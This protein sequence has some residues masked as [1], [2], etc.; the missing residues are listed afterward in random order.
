MAIPTNR[1]SRWFT[2]GLAAASLA[3][4]ICAD[5]QDRFANPRMR[6]T[7]QSMISTDATVRSLAQGNGLYLHFAGF[8]DDMGAFV[9]TYYLRS[10]YALYPQNVLVGEPSEIIFSVE[11][12]L[13]GNFD[14]SSSWLLDHRTWTE[15]TLNHNSDGSI[16]MTVQ[17][18]TPPAN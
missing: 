18:V 9:F 6:S 7:A 3:A 1:L 5:F 12:L 10:F 13:A 4:G 15:V 2:L 16:V 8:P 11:Q 17:R 14:P